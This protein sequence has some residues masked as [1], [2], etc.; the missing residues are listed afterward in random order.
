MG[1]TRPGRGEE[2]DPYGS[3]WSLSTCSFSA[4]PIFLDL[5]V[6]CMVLCVPLAEDKFVPVTLFTVAQVHLA[7]RCVL[8][9]RRKRGC[10]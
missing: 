5:K 8:C 4:H 10:Q 6:E 9:S 3:P 2:T 7:G 1:G